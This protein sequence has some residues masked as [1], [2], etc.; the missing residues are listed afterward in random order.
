[1][2][3]VKGKVRLSLGIKILLPV[4]VASLVILVS[5]WFFFRHSRMEAVEGHITHRAESIAVSIDQFAWIVGVS[6]ELDRTVRAL[7]GARGV[8]MIAVV[9]RDP[10]TAL[11]VSG[12]GVRAPDFEMNIE[13]R[14]DEKVSR[15]LRGGKRLSGFFGDG[16]KGDMKFLYI[17]PVSLKKA[18]GADLVPGAVYIQLETGAGFEDMTRYAGQVNTVFTGSL[19]FLIGLLYFLL[20]RYVFEP[21]RVIKDVLDLRAVGNKDVYVSPI[22]AD[23]IGEVGRALN[24]L[25]ENQDRFKIEIRRSH[26][27]AVKAGREAQKASEVKSQFLANM[28]HELRTPLNSSLGMMRLL[29]ETSLSAEQRAMADTAFQSS[30]N[31]LAIVNDI[32][33]LSKIEADEMVLERIGFDVIYVFD[34]VIHTLKP[35]VREKHLRFDVCF[36]KEDF[37]YLVGD[38]LR[39]TR[40]LTNMV[41]N[42]V[43]Y[44]DRGRVEFRAFCRKLDDGHVEVRCEV[45]DTGIG[46]S[47][48]NIGRIF[49]KFVQADTS[50]TRRY[51]GT[52]LG[53]AITKELVGLMGGE[54]GV[55]SEVDVGSTFWCT[56]PFEITDQLSEEKRFRKSKRVKGTVPPG[57]AR[58]LV[59]ED[60]PLNQMYIKKLLEKFGI[61][62][63]E[64]V[65]SGQKVVDKYREGSWD[66]ILMDCHMPEKN[67]YDATEEIRTLEEKTGGHVP[68]V[69]MTANAMV[70]EREKCL[71]YGMDDY[72]SKPLNIEE[73]LDILGQWMCFEKGG[74]K[75]PEQEPKTGINPPVNF[76]LLRAITQGNKEMEQEFVRVFVAQSDKNLK[77]LE[78]CCTRGDQKLWCETAHMFKGGSGVIGAEALSGLCEQGQHFEGSEEERL[79]LF[80]SIKREYERVKDFLRQNDLTIC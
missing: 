38:P 61:G 77:I 42:A 79:R 11:A 29:M 2:T 40:V 51:G 47:R 3:D 78:E 28:S 23:E 36:K 6:P 48:E 33:D 44:T 73:M 58:I 76:P 1:M 31:L 26:A 12:D 9:Q 45:E 74:E 17:L 57:Q 56:I 4:F 22:R 43:K 68:I 5:V 35:L 8:G 55:E 25:L 16:V 65:D 27:A 63:H 32:L 50:T 60:H 15:A 67:G 10:F 18:P 39:L 54:I 30:R 66:V 7:A 13:K 24:T 80:G 69:A 37:P 21:T 41:S 34:S 70:G 72:I 14:F 52:G 49:E 20:R 62:Y 75:G 19:L 59:A 64:L 71:R 46:I 53:L